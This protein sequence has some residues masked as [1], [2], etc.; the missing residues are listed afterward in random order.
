LVKLRVLEQEADVQQAAVNSA[1]ESLQ[2]INNQYQAGIIDYN[3]VVSV[4]TSTLSNERSALSLLGNRLT[5]SVQLIAALGGG[6]HSNP[7]ENPAGAEPTMSSA[8]SA[9]AAL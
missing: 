7:L 1:R 4:Q 3:S 5:T 6:W 9:D 8:E 2:R